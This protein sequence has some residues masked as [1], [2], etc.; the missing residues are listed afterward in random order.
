MA[1]WQKELEFAVEA[2]R[3]AG[4]FTLGYFQNAA[5]EVEFKADRTPVTVADRG[6]EQRI[7]E[8][9]ARAFP[10]DGILGEEQG[11]E[12]GSSGRRWIVDPIDGT[13]SFVRG[14]PLYGVLLGLEV[15][16]ECMVGAAGFPALSMTL[17]AA[18]GEGAWHDGKRIHVAPTSELGQA[19]LCSSDI[20]PNHMGEANPGFQN[21]LA[22][23][24]RYRGWG[25]CYG[26]ALVAMGRADIMIDPILAPWDCAALIPVLEE[27]GGVFVDWQGRR[28]AH[29]G[30]GIGTTPGLVDEVRRLLGA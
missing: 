21:L 11:E 20:H 17:W 19:T 24:G 12:P 5:L 22:A 8:M 27:A 15:D 10:R 9:L 3:Q 6:A 29:G 4:E 2:V 28:T 13:Q 18:R 26:Y 25:D 1:S 7:R 30:N 14:V 23:C 16:G